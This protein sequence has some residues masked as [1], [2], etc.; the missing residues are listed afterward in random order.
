MHPSA[1]LSVTDRFALAINGLCRA[2][3]TRISTPAMT[4][5]LIVLIWSRLS[6]ISTR[7]QALAA[8][9]RAG[10]LR[11]P[12]AAH[13]RAA[14]PRPAAPPKLR[15]PRGFGWLL[16]LVPYEAAGFA[17]QIRHL[18]TDP[19][20]AALIA[21]T[22]RMGQTLRPLFRMLGLEASLLTPPLAPL[23]PVDD[24][25]SDPS[26]TQ[27]TQ[28]ARPIPPREARFGTEPEAEILKTA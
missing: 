13:R 26:E 24:P 21:A 2:V 28:A 1:T 17:S 8:R 7:F 6:R 10:T 16:P 9:I 15:L 14:P 12:P 19:E 4:G 22:P 18:L 27:A 3:A 5:A 23:P 25:A 11:K 20:I